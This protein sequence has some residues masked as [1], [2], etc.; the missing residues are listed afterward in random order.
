MTT[1]RLQCVGGPH[2]GEWRD[3]PLICNKV[4]LVKP[5]YADAMNPSAA[6]KAEDVC[7]SWD[8]MVRAT[9]DAIQKTT[10]VVCGDHLVPEKDLPINNPG[11]ETAK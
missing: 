6:Q 5:K 1:R 7:P 4:M 2:H 9:Q 3:V 8:N 10:Y 11:Q